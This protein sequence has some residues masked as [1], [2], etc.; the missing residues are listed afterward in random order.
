[1]FGIKNPFKKEK[2]EN[3]PLI[4]ETLQPSIKQESVKV[5]EA[6]PQES[7][8]TEIE[9]LLAKIDALKFQYEALN[10]K[11]NNIEKMIKEIYQM[12]KESS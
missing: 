7:K 4:Q 6:L 2:S 12:A 10:E 11:I 5:E 8:K 3:L 9:V 1:M